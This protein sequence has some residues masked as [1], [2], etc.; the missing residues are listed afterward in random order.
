MNPA[1]VK[2]EIKAK[3]FPDNMLAYAKTRSAAACR[4]V[5]QNL[6]MAGRIQERARLVGERR[7]FDWCLQSYGVAYCGIVLDPVVKKRTKREFAVLVGGMIGRLEAEWG[8]SEDSGWQ[9]VDRRGI[10]ANEA[11]GFWESLLDLELEFGLRREAAKYEE[12][13]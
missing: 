7:A 4:D 11:Y 1:M 5:D 13:S 2:P 12:Q 9:Q 10:P 8:F 6:G 3:R